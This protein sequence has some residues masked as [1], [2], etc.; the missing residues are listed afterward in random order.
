MQQKNSTSSYRK[1]S[2]P[3]ISVHFRYQLSEQVPARFVAI[4]PLA[5]W[6]GVAGALTRRAIVHRTI[7]FRCSN[8]NR[9]YT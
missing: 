2:N 9:I 4:L 7:A 3:V 5:E 6:Q 1:M 8:L